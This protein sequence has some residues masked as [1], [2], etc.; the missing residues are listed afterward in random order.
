M[1]TGKLIVGKTFQVGKTLFIY[2]IVNL[3][4]FLRLIQHITFTYWKLTIERLE[5]RVKY[6]QS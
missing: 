1:S 5:K 4:Y 3:R 2:E 6:S